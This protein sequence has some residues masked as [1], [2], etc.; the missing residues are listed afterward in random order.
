MKKV[1]AIA[2]SLCFIV[3]LTACGNS[4]LTEEQIRKVIQEEIKANDA[5]SINE[6]KPGD[7]LSTPS[8]GN[9]KLPIS[10]YDNHFATITLL[11]VTKKKEADISDLNDYWHYGGSPYY[12]RYIYEVKINGNVDKKFAGKEIFIGLEFEN[13]SEFSPESTTINA[14]GAFSFTYLAYS[15]K[16][17]NVIIPHHAYIPKDKF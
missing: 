5:S 4:G 1:L 10:G 13:Y 17:E 14:D 16:N 12:L 9:F 11:D 2:L 15:N 3:C 8:G 6:F 7:K